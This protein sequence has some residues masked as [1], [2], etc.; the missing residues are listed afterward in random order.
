[1]LLKK[2]KYIRKAHISEPVISRMYI[3]VE[4]E[5]A[6]TWKEPKENC[7]KRINSAKPF[8]L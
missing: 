1:M 7:T 6:K 5:E 3:K 2:A 8:M 4:I